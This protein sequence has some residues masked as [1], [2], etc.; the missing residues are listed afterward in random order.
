MFK[1]HLMPADNASLL[2]RSYLHYSIN[3]CL[4]FQEAICVA[5]GIHDPCSER[6]CP[7]SEHWL[8]NLI[9]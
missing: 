7:D 4:D 8:I 1:I 6:E 2:S 9:H 3:F 5:T